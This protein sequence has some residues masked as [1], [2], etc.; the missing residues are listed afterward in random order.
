MRFRRLL[1]S[2]LAASMIVAIL[3][4]VGC[5]GAPTDT[6]SAV[7]TLTELLELRRAGTADAEAY[8]PYFSDSALATAMA[9]SVGEDHAPAVPPWDSIYVSAESTQG[10]DVVVVWRAD[11]AFPG[12]GTATL[13]KMRTEGDGWIVEDAIDASADI[14]SPLKIV[15]D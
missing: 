7:A 12:W 8:A 13:F 3:L 9:D 15:D 14:P 1:L 11:D 2:A 6:H 5:S 4:V 10:A